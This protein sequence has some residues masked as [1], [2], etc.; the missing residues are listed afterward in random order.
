MNTFRLIGFHF[1]DVLT[2]MLYIDML[3]IHVN[4]SIVGIVD[5]FCWRRIAQH[6]SDD[7][8][9][10]HCNLLFLAAEHRTSAVRESPHSSTHHSALAS[11][12]HGIA[13]RISAGLVCLSWRPPNQLVKG[14]LRWYTDIQWYTSSWHEVNLRIQYKRLNSPYISYVNLM[15]F[16]LWLLMFIFLILFNHLKAMGRECV[17]LCTVLLRPVHAQLVG[18]PQSGVFCTPETLQARNSLKNPQTRTPKSLAY[19]LFLTELESPPLTP[20]ARLEEGF[21]NRWFCPDA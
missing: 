17:F 10:M 9:V 8:D 11:T 3:T 16:W 21:G 14:P 5:C 7:Q 13:T 19:K 20:G 12:C 1:I 18:G 6:I 4:Y 15:V 2:H